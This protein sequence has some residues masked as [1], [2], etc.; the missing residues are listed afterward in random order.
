MSAA[1]HGQGT[2][3][4]NNRNTPVGIDA[5]IIFGPSGAG[6]SGSEWKADVIA[7]PAGTPFSQLVPVPNSTTTFR[8]GATAGYVNS[9]MIMI[10]NISAGAQATVAMR[11]YNGSTYQSSALLGTSLPITI[12]TGNPLSS[13]PGTPT[14]MIGLQGF[15][16]L[17]PEP[18]TYALAIFGA[19]IVM[20]F[21]R[22]SAERA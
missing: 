20:L 22:R 19:A 5:K 9:L 6:L 18:S 16:V 15:V 21:R 7:G 11:A 13:P 12:P 17:F 8:T 3:V 2:V 1:V 10:P 14:D 4:F